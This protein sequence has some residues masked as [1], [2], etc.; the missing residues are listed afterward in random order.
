MATD[1]NWAENAQRAGIDPADV[2]QR[3]AAQMKRE[4]DAAKERAQ[5]EPEPE[6]VPEVYVVLRE[7][8]PHR[9]KA[10]SLGKV[11]D[12]EVEAFAMSEAGC[13]P[14]FRFRLAHVLQA[15]NASWTW[16]HSR[17]EALNYRVHIAET[18]RLKG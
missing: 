4:S 17:A 12:R 7:H 16:E 1:D 6:A 3:A 11:G 18:I 13:M 14:Q 2:M 8:A 15:H 9:W 10:A 5:F